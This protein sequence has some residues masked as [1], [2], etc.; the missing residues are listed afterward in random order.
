MVK[1]QLRIGHDNKGMGSGWHLK[2]VTIESQFDGRKWFCECNKWLDKNESDGL[3]ERE[4]LAIEQHNN[5]SYETKYEEKYEKKL[6]NYED[7]NEKKSDFFLQE[8]EFSIMVNS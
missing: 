4:L 1:Y 2:E 7:V 3:I 6:R 8:N 5:N